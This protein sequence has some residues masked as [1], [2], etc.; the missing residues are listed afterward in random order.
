MTVMNAT[1]APNRRAC[2]AFVSWVMLTNTGLPRDPD[3]RRG[4][5]DRE[6]EEEVRDDD[7]HDAGPD[8]LT[9]GATDPGRTARGGEAV[10]AVDEDHRHREE[11]Q[12]EEGPEH[13]DRR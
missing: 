4:A 6:A 11:Q 7:G 8:R 3:G 13:V 12:L 10:V 5:P 1:P 9:D 2:S